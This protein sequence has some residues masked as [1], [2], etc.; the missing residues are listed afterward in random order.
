MLQQSGA[1]GDVRIQVFQVETKSGLSKKSGQPYRMEVCQCAVH[2]GGQI[3]VGELVLPKDHPP[4]QPGD[5][6]ATFT[7]AVDRDKR[8]GGTLERLTPLKLASVSKVG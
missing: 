2:A 8:I 5:Y 6:S 3:V 4:V 1:M 7:V